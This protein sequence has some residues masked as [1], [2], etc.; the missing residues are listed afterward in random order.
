MGAAK[1]SELPVPRTRRLSPSRREDSEGFYDFQRSGTS[2]SF[3]DFGTLLESPFQPKRGRT[4]MYAELRWERD[5]DL[6]VDPFGQL[7]LHF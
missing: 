3:E 6:V 2:S 4:V 1:T 5:L 7:M